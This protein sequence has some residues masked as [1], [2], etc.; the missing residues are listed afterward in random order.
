M[1][2]FRAAA[3]L[4][5]AAY[6]SF[7]AASVRPANACLSFRSNGPCTARCLSGA[8][9]CTGRQLCITNTCGAGSISCDGRLFSCAITFPR[10]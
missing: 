4:V 2:N 8:A 6:V 1:R 10:G 7:I 5:A 9:S 3:V